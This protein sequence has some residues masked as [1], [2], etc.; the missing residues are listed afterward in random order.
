MSKTDPILS[1]EQEQQV[2]SAIASAEKKTS[3]EVRVYIEH[4]CPVEALDRAAFIFE[5][6]EIHKTKERNGVLVYVAAADRKYAII[7]DAG[8]HTKVKQEFW[9]TVSEAMLSE[10]KSGDMVAGIIHGIERAGE[11]LRNYFP[12]GN[13]DKNELSDDIVFGND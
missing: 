7:G 8:I 3:G 6:L 12:Y 4:Y 2:K 10:F 1:P 13:D 11:V 5:K 9:N